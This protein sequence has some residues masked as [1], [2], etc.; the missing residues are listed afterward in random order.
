MNKQQTR[1]ATNKET[2]RKRRGAILIWTALILL[3]LL[4]MVG[5]VIDSGFMMVSFRHSHNAADAAAMAAAMDMLYGKT[6]A[7]A[8]T[9]GETFAKGAG[10]NNLPGATVTI[11]IPPSSGNYAGSSNYA[12]AIVSSPK[13]TY[14]IHVLP[15]VPQGHTTV[16][17]AVAGFESVAAGE[18]VV[19]LNP[20]AKPGLKISGGGSLCV[21]G[22]VLVNSTG[23]GVDE[24]GNTV[25]NGLDGASASNNTSVKADQI[26]ISGGVNNPDNFQS[27]PPGDDVLDAGTQALY[28]DP[29]NYMPTPTTSN[30]V[31]DVD[32]GAPLA[33]SGGLALNNPNDANHVHGGGPN[34]I[35]NP[36]AANETMVLHPGIYTEIKI[37]GGI[38]RF[39]PGIYVLR[40]S[41]QGNTAFSLDITGGD[42]T[43]DNLMFYNTGSTYD[44]VTG[45]PDNGDF[46]VPLTP[47]PSAPAGNFGDIKI[48]A[49]FT[50][51][52]LD[53]TLYS[54]GGIDVSDFDNML[55]YQ[56]RLSVAEM[57][58]EGNSSAGNLKG[59]LYAK[60]GEV[61]I[62]G[63]GTYDAQFIVGSMDITG[64]GDITIQYNGS[65]VA[66]APQVFLVQ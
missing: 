17:R 34:F 37:T 23:G 14:F 11:N 3:G 5:L 61:K 57:Q 1:K 39:E 51:C 28:P 49:S 38:V 21:E 9:T 13:P 4:G 18:G 2:A 45:A 31:F 53:S 52:G 22:A 55:F 59:T 46:T 44:P 60:F 27:N 33:T 15:G 56:R 29:L 63:Q 48:N 54:P 26:M 7:E 20:N 65:G 19:A 62:S 40:P 36:G 10:Y 50:F 58:I 30:G 24:N 8:I 64:Q 6:N 35:E 47:E 16:G 43:A 12:E 25:G 32:R 66:K 42:V 41:A